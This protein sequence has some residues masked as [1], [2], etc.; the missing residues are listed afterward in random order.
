MA[1]KEKV[2]NSKE[3]KSLLK[4]LEELKGESTSGEA[5][6]IRRKLRSLG[7]YLSKNKAQKDEDEDEEESK[8]KHSKKDK[9]EKKSKKHRKD[10]DEE[11]D[12]EDDEEEDED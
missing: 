6:A 3:I 11:D 9:E 4:Q 7:Y 5:R 1:T 2:D 10:E 8:P 12:D